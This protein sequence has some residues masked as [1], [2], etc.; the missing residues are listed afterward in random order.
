MGKITLINNDTHK[1][2]CVC[3][4]VVYF[5]LK[6]CTHVML[7]YKPHLLQK[8]APKKSLRKITCGLLGDFETKPLST[9]WFS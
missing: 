2:R 3:K 1:K 5:L 9:R 6:P 8:F 7:Y 4:E